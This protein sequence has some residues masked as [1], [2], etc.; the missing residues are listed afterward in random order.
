MGFLRMPKTYFKDHKKYE[1]VS[2]RIWVK[3]EAKHS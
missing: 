3:M 1:L 2:E